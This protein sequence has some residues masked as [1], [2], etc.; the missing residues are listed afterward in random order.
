MPFPTSKLMRHHT[1]KDR[2][3]YIYCKGKPLKPVRSF[4]T[5]D[6]RPVKYPSDHAAVVHIFKY[7]H[8]LK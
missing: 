6:S 8:D 7:S 1:F 3:D 2:I 5:I 4:F